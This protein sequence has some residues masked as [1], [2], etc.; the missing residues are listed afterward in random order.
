MTINRQLAKDRGLSEDV[1]N[2]IERIHNLIG[3][4]TRAWVLSD[5][6]FSQ[7]RKDK[8]HCLEY[9]LQRLW[10]FSEDHGYHRYAYEYEFKCQWVGKTYRCTKTGKEF[11]I[12]YEVNQCDLFPVGEGFV[13][14]G[15]VYCY[16]RFSGVEEV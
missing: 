13:D 5:E 4:F 10:G 7:E 16:A 11:T 12:P 15:R 2:E 14:V 8:L 3:K 9:Q 6:L 1:I